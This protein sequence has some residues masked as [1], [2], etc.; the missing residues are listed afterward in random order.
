MDFDRLT[1]V[2]GEKGGRQFAPVNSA[3]TIVAVKGGEVESKPQKG[4]A[5]R[6]ALKAF[7]LIKDD[8]SKADMSDIIEDATDRAKRS[9]LF[10]LIYSFENDVWTVINSELFSAEA[11]I[12]AFNSAV[13]NFSS[14]FLEL[15]GD[16]FAEKCAAIEAAVKAGTRS[17]ENKADIQSTHD[18]LGKA[19]K[20]LTSAHEATV[21][22]LADNTDAPASS[23]APSVQPA[24]QKSGDNSQENEVDEATKAALVKELVEAAKPVLAD[25]V[26]SAVAEATKAAAP[27]PATTTEPTPAPNAEASKSETKTENVDVAAAIKSA[28]AEAIPQIT[29]A[30]KKAATDAVSAAMS[31][32]AKAARE[33]SAPGGHEP[34]NAQKSQEQIREE[35]KGKDFS[36]AISTLL[37][38]NIK[39][40]A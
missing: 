4:G 38:T 40:A 3:A 18:K 37:Q 13:D 36:G 32:A 23:N 12:E 16:V 17:K 6:A 24:A 7:G 25:A 8:A 15:A 29:D 5:F 27:A 10:D 35:A 9:A 20:A 19:I 22:L 30:A 14:A 21:R 34:G 1:L 39:K 26:K 31:D 11:R 2:M 33:N 28:M